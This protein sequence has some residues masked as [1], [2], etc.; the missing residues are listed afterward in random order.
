MA[1]EK[2]TA[3]RRPVRRGGRKERKS[4]PYG[5]VHIQASF[6]NTIVTFTDQKSDRSHVVL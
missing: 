4:I 1:D 6:N 3:P 2:T 5:K